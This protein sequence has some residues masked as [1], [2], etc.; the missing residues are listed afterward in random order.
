M[1][2]SQGSN[3]SPGSNAGPSL[4]QLIADTINYVT[5]P[6]VATQLGAATVPIAIWAGAYLGVPSIAF[7]APYIPLVAGTFA[8]SF[9]VG[10]AVASIPPVKRFLGNAFYD[11]LN[12]T[13]GEQR[14]Q[15]WSSNPSFLDHF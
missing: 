14:I 3:P 2:A 5:G 11:V 12:F 6:Q 15:D 7:A 1:N 4:E 9:K 8:I 13:F 10:E